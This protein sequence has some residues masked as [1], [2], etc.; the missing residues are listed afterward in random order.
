MNDRFEK[1]IAFLRLLKESNVYFELGF[2]REESIMIEVAV[3]GER[4]EVELWKTGPLKLK[5]SKALA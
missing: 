1:L 4:S 5:F 2:H 3:P